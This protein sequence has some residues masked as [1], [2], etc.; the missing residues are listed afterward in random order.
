MLVL[1]VS[2]LFSAVI[3]MI[4]GLW[5]GLL[6][7]GWQLPNNVS[8]MQHGPLMVVAFFATL[9]ALERAVGLA[10]LWV[11]LSPLILGLAGFSSLLFGTT[12]FSLLLFV[13]GSG[14]Y[15]I[16]A[17][18]LFILQKA[19]FSFVMALGA[20]AL[21]VANIL[22]T[23]NI[24]LNTVV[25]FWASYLVLI[26]T[27]ERLELSRF[28]K[29]PKLAVQVFLGSVVINII[30]LL[31]MLVNQDIGIR[32]VA[33]AFLVMAAWLLRY[34]IARVNI[35]RDGVYRFMAAA[36]LA[37]YFWLAVAGIWFLVVGMRLAGPQ[38]DG[39]LHAIFL[40]FVFSMVFAHAPVIFPAVL[41]LKI[42]FSKILYAPLVLL[43]VSL[44][45]RLY[46]DLYS[47]QLRYWGGM[48]S[49][50]AIVLYFIS[51]MAVTLIA[52]KFPKPAQ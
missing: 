45:V 28:V 46:G 25:I 8:A 47:Y 11:Y 12:R 52:S 21:F 6:R 51:A 20:L 39:P 9:I 27:G 26:I 3:L 35:K 37:A 32:I 36:L 31:I 23:F 43:H 24:P 34:D 1:R 14:V 33:F 17:I 22:W 30:G 13:V 19:D 38:Y 41:K 15:L 10:K 4:S 50:I 42:K 16:S 49:A 7:M 2:L 18:Y 40:G 5:A 29:K 44:A 48:L